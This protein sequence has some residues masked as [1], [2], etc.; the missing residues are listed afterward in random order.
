MSRTI[1]FRDLLVCEELAHIKN[2]IELLHPDNDDLVADILSK[3]GFD[4]EYPVLYVPSK[5]RDMQNKIEVG[6]MAVGE[7]SLNRSFI[8]SP[9]CSIT[10]RM[11]AASYTDPT[12]T[13]ELAGLMGHSINYKVLLSE[14][15]EY[16]GEELPNE[17]L[18]PDREHVAKQI[19]QL[20]DIRDAIRGDMYNEAGDLKTFAEYK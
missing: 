16:D 8:N 14:D 20:A 12:M 10:E 17:M 15:A 13:R 9:M 19:K 5:H 2:E 11:V 6:F 4:V 1:S 7:I 3:I 18:E